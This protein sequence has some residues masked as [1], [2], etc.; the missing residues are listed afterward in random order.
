MVQSGCS[1]SGSKLKFATRS[2][3]V[4][5]GDIHGLPSQAKTFQT[6]FGGEFQYK[7]LTNESQE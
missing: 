7:R 4:E 2:A 5:K 3:V 1:G 6:E